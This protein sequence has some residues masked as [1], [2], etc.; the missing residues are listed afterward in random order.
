MFGLDYCVANLTIMK[1][2]E[3]H[4]QT[5]P[6]FPTKKGLVEREMLLR[7]R[8]AVGCTR[9]SEVES[10]LR[11]NSHSLTIVGLKKDIYIV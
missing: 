7:K 6:G 4:Y 3:F 1:S 8:Q 5:L 10:S 11:V 2:I 9:E